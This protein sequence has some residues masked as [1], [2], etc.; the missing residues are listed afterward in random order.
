MPRILIVEDEAALAKGIQ[1]NFEIEG[2]E[3]E[4]AYTG[5]TQK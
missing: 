5:P 2:Y 1:F 4:V 3:V